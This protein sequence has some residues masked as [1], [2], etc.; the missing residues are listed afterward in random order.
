MMNTH[1]HQPRA[2]CNAYPNVFAF[3]WKVSAQD[4]A[5]WEVAKNESPRTHAKNAWADAPRRLMQRTALAFRRVARAALLFCSRCD[6]A[7]GSARQTL[8]ARALGS[9][10]RDPKLLRQGYEWLNIDY[11]GSS[12]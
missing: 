8:A 2:G 3:P 6:S 12:T 4:Q 10:L 5:G 11:L 9:K 7:E 1:L